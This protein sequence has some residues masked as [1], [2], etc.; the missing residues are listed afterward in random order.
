M[1]KSRLHSADLIFFLCDTSLGFN[2]VLI[3]ASKGLNDTGYFDIARESADITYDDFVKKYYDVEQPVLIEGIGQDWPAT[4]CW[5]EPYLR[6][7]LANKKDASVASLWYWMNRDTLGEDFDTPDLINQTLDRPDLLPRNQHIRIWVHKQGHVSSWH[8]D[9]NIISVFNLQVTGS[10]EWF[11]V[12]PDTP[13]ECYPYTTFGVIKDESDEESLLDKQYTR[14]ML[15]EGDLLYLP[16]LWFH[17]VLALDEENISLNWVFTKKETKVTSK[18]L[19]REYERY[20]LSEYLSGH[21]FSLV[22]KAFAKI[23]EKIPGYLYWKWRYD[24][25]IRTPLPKKRFALLRRVLKET[26]G[27]W[28]LLLNV[29]ALRSYL[30]SGAKSVDKL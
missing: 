11:L 12:S 4:K 29:K 25:M 10:K 17:K 30:K 22:R 16:P 2:G 18:T 15:K 14:F 20:A 27:L 23:N 5:S 3:M 13:F 9:S 6:S 8:Y 28:P 19:E 26:A 1:S 24:E 7:K 21:R